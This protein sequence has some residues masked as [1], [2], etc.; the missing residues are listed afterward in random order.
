M[1]NP[2]PSAVEIVLSDEERA[3]LVHRS[4]VAAPRAAARAQIVL[5]AAEGC[6]NAEV[7]RRV[8]VSVI[9]VGKWR[10]KFAAERLE[11]LADAARIGRPKAGLVLTGAERDQLTRWARRATT[12]CHEGCVSHGW[13]KIG[14]RD[15][16]AA[17]KGSPCESGQQ[18]RRS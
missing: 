13:T 2:G 9:S 1:V 4:A 16:H 18:Y 12:A 5:A 3:E 17:G 6:S 8:G 11:G 15:L 14:W 10:R 7:A